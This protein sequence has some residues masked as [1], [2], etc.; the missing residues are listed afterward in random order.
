MWPLPLWLQHTYSTPEGT[1]DPPNPVLP[2]AG[3]QLGVSGSAPPHPPQKI[4]LPLSRECQGSG[5]SPV[6]LCKCWGPRSRN[7]HSP[8]LKEL[9]VFREPGIYQEPRSLLALMVGL[10]CWGPSPCPQGL[11]SLWLSASP[12]GTACR[13][14]KSP[15]MVPLLPFFI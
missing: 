4:N 1:A 11:D 13:L 10:R 9:T 7:S 12:L 5:G 15:T 3:G 8:C 14:E 2:R 6:V